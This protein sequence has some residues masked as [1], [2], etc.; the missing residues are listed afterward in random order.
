VIDEASE[1]YARYLVL[2]RVSAAERAAIVEYLARARG[3]TP[4]AV[5]RSL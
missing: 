5:D 4:G 2:G 1:R 3:L